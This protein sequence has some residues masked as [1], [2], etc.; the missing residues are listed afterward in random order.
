LVI[1]QINLIFI[2]VS[3]VLLYVVSGQD[4]RPLNFV[5]NTTLQ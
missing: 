3:I 1:S 2:T 5:V 4:Q